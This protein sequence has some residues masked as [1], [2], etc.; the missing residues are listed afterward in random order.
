MVRLS[1]RQQSIISE[2]CMS[3]FEWNKVIG[4]IL[5]ALL[6]IKV[7]DIGGD[8]IIHA[9]VPEQHAYPI[10]GVEQAPAG[11]QQPQKQEIE[12]PPIE[13]LLASASVEEGKKAFRKCAVC[14]NAEQGA[15]NKVGPN[16][17]GKFG[18]KMGEGDF[19][20]SSA[21]QE[22]DVELTAEVLN[23]FLHDPRGYV[24]GTKMAFGGVKN[25]QERANLIAYLK[26][27]Q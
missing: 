5:V 7:A 19:A 15:G 12:L 11:E 17:W 13:P 8:A 1:A 14:H 18:H 25:D 6:V 24:R 10:E 22:K 9:K 2:Q 20:F 16:L 27:L 3:A 26:S 21:M 4:A 23:K